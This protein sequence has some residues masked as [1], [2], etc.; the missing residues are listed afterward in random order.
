MGLWDLS[1]LEWL[2]VLE[3]RRERVM[4]LVLVNWLGYKGNSPIKKEA[5]DVKGVCELE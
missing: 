5:D 1:E 4:V 2:C 3:K